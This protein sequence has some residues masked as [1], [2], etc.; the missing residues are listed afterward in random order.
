MSEKEIEFI[1]QARID[2]NADMR[3]TDHYGPAL[4]RQ[5]C[6]VRGEVAFADK[7]GLGYEQIRAVRRGSD[8]GIDFEVFIGGVRLTFDVKTRDASGNDLLVKAE[9]FSFATC[10]DYFVL[11]QCIDKRVT[12]IGWE[13]PKL[14]QCMR[15]EKLRVPTHV[16]RLAELRP[17]RVLD[18]LMA[19]RDR[20]AQSA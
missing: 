19:L 10:A 6:G 20:Q 11:A 16:R 13:D 9:I 3:N 12:L 17:M 5:I 18:N 4:A 2:L 7:Y 8:G 15:V 14:V 1:A